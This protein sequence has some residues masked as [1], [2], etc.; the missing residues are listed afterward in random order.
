[1]LTRYHSRV[2]GVLAHSRMHL[3]DPPKQTGG[4]RWPEPPVI[5]CQGPE[6]NWRHRTFQARA[7]PT[8][9]P[10]PDG[11]RAHRSLAM[12]STKM[13]TLMGLEPTTFAVT[14]RRSNQLSYSAKTGIR[15]LGWWARLGSNQRPPA[16]EADALPLSYAPK[17][18]SAP[19]TK[20][21][22][23]LPFAACLARSGARAG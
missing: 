22:V 5:W 13:A 16:C 20:R 6:S 1:M 17:P 4:P 9:L 21:Y 19:W 11:R 7:L 23:T 15:R 3:K 14:G 10:W 8:E 18:V 12:R 2:P